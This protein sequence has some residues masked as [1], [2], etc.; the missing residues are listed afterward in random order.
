VKL[1]LSWVCGV[2]FIILAVFSLMFTIFGNGAFMSVPWPAAVVVGALG[3]FLVRHTR[4]SDRDRISA[5]ELLASAIREG[6][7]DTVKPRSETRREEPRVMP[8][9]RML[10]ILVVIGVLGTVGILLIRHGIEHWGWSPPYVAMISL[11][12]SSLAG[13]LSALVVARERQRRKNRHA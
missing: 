2:L 13:A 9:N 12:V 5:E 10:A 11:S 6:V 8:W 1:T 3:V 4:L 7:E